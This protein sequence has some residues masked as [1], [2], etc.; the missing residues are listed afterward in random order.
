[1]SF[2][3]HSCSETLA[4]S[5]IAEAGN[6]TDDKITTKGFENNQQ[7]SHQTQRQDHPHPG[8]Q[9]YS[10]SYS[11]IKAK[12]GIKFA[13]V[14]CVPCNC[15]ELYVAQTGRLRQ[16]SKPDI[17]NTRNT[18]IW[19]SQRSPLWQSTYWNMINTAFYSTSSFDTATICM[20]RMIKESL[21]V[22][23]TK[24]NQRS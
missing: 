18:Y 12:L 16:I 24:R 2:S 14:Y 9:K 19:D 11:P 7:A 13:G 17:E 20:E 21:D 3:D 5:T 23:P 22:R 15:P 8:K 6:H 4:T 1:M 10:H